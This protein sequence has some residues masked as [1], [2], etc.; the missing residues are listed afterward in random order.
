[1]EGGWEGRPAQ[2]HGGAVAVDARGD[3]CAARVR[4]KKSANPRRRT[5]LYCAHADRDTR[6][7]T[8]R[9]HRRQPHVRARAC[10]MRRRAGGRACA[11][12]GGRASGRTE[13]TEVLRARASCGGRAG[14][15]RGRECVQIRGFP[16]PLSLC[17]YVCVSLCLCVCVSVCLCVCV[18]VSLCLCVP[19]SPQG[20]IRS[21]FKI[22]QFFRKMTRKPEPY[23]KIAHVKNPSPNHTKPCQ[24]LQTTSC[25]GNTLASPISK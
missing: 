20:S 8:N 7:R 12:A 5:L 4:R 23:Q 11:R 9:S 17:L 24:I 16:C 1:M 6:T 13:V 15:R 2:V 10:G 25:L 19:M 14:A 21:Y 18:S 3:P 22:W